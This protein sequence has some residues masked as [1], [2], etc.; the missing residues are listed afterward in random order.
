MAKVYFNFAELQIKIMNQIKL[1]T[2][3]LI[4]LKIQDIDIFFY[5][6]VWKS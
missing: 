6:K 3:Q 4:K 5:L 1:L 2:A